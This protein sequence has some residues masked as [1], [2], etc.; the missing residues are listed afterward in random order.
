LAV[1]ENRHFNLTP[2]NPLSEAEHMAQT[3]RL[4]FH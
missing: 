4:P 3:G 2:Y 1:R